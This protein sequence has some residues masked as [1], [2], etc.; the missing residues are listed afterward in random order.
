MVETT[1]QYS[2]GRTE[3]LDIPVAFMPGEII[4]VVKKQTGAVVV[5]RVSPVV[6]ANMAI[7]LVQ[8]LT[9]LT[10]GATSQVRFKAKV[11]R[12]PSAS[13]VPTINWGP[14]WNAVYAYDEHYAYE[15]WSNTKY[16]DIGTTY[17]DIISPEF[18]C[19]TNGNVIFH[20]SLL[21]ADNPA[22]PYPIY[23][24]DFQ[25]LVD[26]VWEDFTNHNFS[27]GVW[28]TYEWDWDFTEPS[29]WMRLIFYGGTAEQQAESGEGVVIEIV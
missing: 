14:S 18:V 16:S 28:D 6:G 11:T 15:Y 7:D 22:T 5:Q 12:V 24:T 21:L 19:P 26:G 3:T 27:S 2:D 8:Y 9:G 10:P 13:Y 29:E 20:M 25:I 4:S 23:F 1:V 17:T